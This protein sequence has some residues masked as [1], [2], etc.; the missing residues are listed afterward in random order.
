MVLL[1]QTSGDIGWHSLG[2]YSFSA[3]KIGSASIIPTGTGIVTADALK[4]VSTTRFNDGSGV[5]VITLPP[6]D[7]IVLLDDMYGPCFQTGDVNSD[8]EISM[9]DAQKAFMIALGNT[10][11]YGEKC[12]ADCNGDDLITAGD[13]QA[14]FFV[15]LGMDSCSDLLR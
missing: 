2:A 6:L 13:A 10:F 11:T 9:G 1:D 5:D 15:V 8:T 3:G 14:I 4:W 7:G 12:R